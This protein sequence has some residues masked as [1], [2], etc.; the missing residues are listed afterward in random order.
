MVWGKY[1]LI[2]VAEVVCKLIMNECF[3]DLWAE[4]SCTDIY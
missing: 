3:Y 1:I 4:A 2:L